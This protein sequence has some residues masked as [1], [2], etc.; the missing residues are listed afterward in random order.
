MYKYKSIGLMKVNRYYQIS[1]DTFRMDS[2]FEAEFGQVHLLSQGSFDGSLI[3]QQ[4]SPDS[5]PCDMVIKV[6]E[7]RYFLSLYLLFNPNTNINYGL[8]QETP[9]PQ[10]L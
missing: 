3:A 7:L 10:E 4:T 9:P 8:S 2:Y 6:E 1:N 5:A